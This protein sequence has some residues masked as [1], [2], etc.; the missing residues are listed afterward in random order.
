MDRIINKL[1]SIQGRLFELSIDKGYDSE[2]F[3]ITYMKS[4][5][6]NHFNSKYDSIQWM[7]EEYILDLLE[8]KFNLIKGK[9][10][11]KDVMFW[12]GYVYCYWSFYTFDSCLSIIETASPKVMLQNYYALHTIDV[13]LAIETLMEQSYQE[14]FNKQNKNVYKF[15]R[16]EYIDRMNVSCN[17]KEYQK[18]LVDLEVETID[19]LLKEKTK[20]NNKIKLSDDIKYLRLSFIHFVL[21]LIDESSWTVRK[22][23]EFK[24]VIESMKNN[25]INF[26]FTNTNFVFIDNIYKELLLYNNL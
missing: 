11:S 6:A 7:G 12:I 15:I 17:E 13:D 26:G 4:S 5:I 24:S 1:C 25:I 21:E 20:Y 8:E 22:K 2:K 16:K 14:K 18:L 10:Y 3:I 23:V 9:V 19:E